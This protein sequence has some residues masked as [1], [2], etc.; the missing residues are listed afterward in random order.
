MTGRVSTNMTAGG[1][2]LNLRRQEAKVNKANNQIGSQNRIQEL[3]DDPIAAGGIIK[4]NKDQN[5]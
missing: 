4:A 1:V 3:R 2:Q 5:I